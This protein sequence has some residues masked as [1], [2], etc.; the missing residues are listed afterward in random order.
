[1]TALRR[2]RWAL[3]FADLCLLLLGFFVLLHA[4]ARGKGD[5]VAQISGYFSG[6][7][8]SAWTSLSATA[9]FEP[10]EAMLTPKGRQAMAK[11]AAQVSERQ[12]FIDVASVGQDRDGRRFDRWELASARLAATARA[13]REAGVPEQRIRILG[14]QENSSPLPAQHLLIRRRKAREPTP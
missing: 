1:M 6:A 13:L 5:A 8:E 3:S 12:E 2:S 10:G 9:L 14:L 11:I 4:S 7:P